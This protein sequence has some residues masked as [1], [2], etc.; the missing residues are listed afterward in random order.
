MMH[1]LDAF[2]TIYLIELVWLGFPV[3]LAW[4]VLKCLR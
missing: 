2:I 3:Y 4:R 1:V